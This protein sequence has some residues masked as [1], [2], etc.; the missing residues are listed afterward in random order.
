[1]GNTKVAK[2][3][4]KGNKSML[5]LNKL[6]F[7]VISLSFS[8]FLTRNSILQLDSTKAILAK[9]LTIKPLTIKPLTIKNQRRIAFLN[10]WLLKSKKSHLEF[11]VLNS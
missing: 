8:N 4:A 5:S 10:Q 7:Q 11:P 6:K 9:S 1:M 3:I 2:K